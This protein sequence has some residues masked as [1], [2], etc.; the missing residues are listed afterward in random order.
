[1]R[2]PKRI[3]VEQ[4]TSINIANLQKVVR[5][6]VT[7]AFP[8]VP[9]EE[10]YNHTLD[11]FKKFQANDQSFEYLSIRNVMGGYRWFFVCPDCKQRASKLFLP[12]DHASAYEHTYKCKR[13]HKILNESVMKANN[14]LYKNVIRPLKHLRVIEQ[15]LEKGH[16]TP[17]KVEE[18]LDKYEE[19]EKEMKKCQE[20]RLYVFKK[21]RGMGLL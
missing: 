5:K 9:E 12:P 8:D 20:Y 18:L 17:S 16:L 13:C 4:C 2:I 14:K 3:S 7:A 6:I 11:E 21:K 10:K 15:K 19:L 1:M